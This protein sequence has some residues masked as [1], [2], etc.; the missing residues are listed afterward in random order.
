MYS[1][2]LQPLKKVVPNPGKL[3]KRLYQIQVNFLP[4]PL[5]W[6]KFKKFVPN[7][8]KL[9]PPSDRKRNCSDNCTLFPI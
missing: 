2:L 3:S 8:G 1:I 5:Q 6:N 7:P 9:L 4:Q